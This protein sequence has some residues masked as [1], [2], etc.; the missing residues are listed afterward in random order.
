[1]A[2]L[3]ALKGNYP[4]LYNI[5]YRNQAIVVE[6]ISYNHPKYTLEDLL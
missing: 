6:V 5:A 2:S 4:I 3:A 1:M